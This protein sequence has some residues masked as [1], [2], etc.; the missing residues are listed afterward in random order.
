MTEA[1]TDFALPALR[2]P[3]RVPFPLGVHAVR[4]RRPPR[5][6]GLPPVSR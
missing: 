6:W 2:D 5:P 3:D 4:A 1:G